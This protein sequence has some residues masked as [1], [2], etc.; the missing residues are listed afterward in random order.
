[1]FT[2]T[3]VDQDFQPTEI[4]NP[5]AIYIRLA[6]GQQIVFE[7]KDEALETVNVQQVIGLEPSEEI[8]IRPVGE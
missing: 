4:E 6:E 3:I 1:M 5:K 8:V 7:V 2:V